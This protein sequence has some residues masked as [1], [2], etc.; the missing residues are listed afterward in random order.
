[1]KLL[2]AAVLYL[3]MMAMSI[4]LAY[5]QFTA[6]PSQGGVTHD[7][8]WSRCTLQQA[9]QETY[10]RFDV[11]S[12]AVLLAKE[13]LPT[14]SHWPWRTTTSYLPGLVA[15]SVGRDCTYVG[16]VSVFRPCSL[17]AL[18][19]AMGYGARRLTA[20][21]TDSQL[22]THMDQGG[23]P[24][25]SLTSEQQEWVR[26]LIRASRKPEAALPEAQLASLLDNAKL[27]LAIH[28]KMSWDHKNRSSGFY[29]DNKAS[30]TLWKRWASGQAKAWESAEKAQTEPGPDVPGGSS[31]C[32]LSSVYKLQEL[33]AMIGKS[34]GS[35]VSCEPGAGSTQVAAYCKIT[36]AGLARAC[37]VAAGMEWRKDGDKW[38]LAAGTAQESLATYSP[39][40]GSDYV[41]GWD[42]FKTR[43][44]EIM[45][46]GKVFLVADSV[47][48]DD[49]TFQR[50]MD[51]EVVKLGEL[52]E[53]QQDYLKRSHESHSEAYR[54]TSGPLPD[55]S[56][57]EI[58]W[59]PGLKIYIPSGDWIL[60]SEWVTSSE[61]PRPGSAKVGSE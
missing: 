31:V 49:Q 30:Q 23:I 11:P 12:M 48:K 52:T 61:H 16:K 9:L 47:W 13:K 7:C 24:Y 18:G 22:Q 59:D 32:E 43:I 53:A 44:R 14:M 55:I 60:H 6:E 25:N 54:E 4:S 20:S 3:L 17:E 58:W 42:A 8:D 38:Q 19:W 29:C 10:D 51:M 46:S 41:R 15:S 57:L 56:E 39:D 36:A 28:A 50:M 21:I 35:S 1:M 45:K 34:D 33:V 27:V 2:K 37:A 5:C 26:Y 40:K